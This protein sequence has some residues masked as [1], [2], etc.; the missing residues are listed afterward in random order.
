M[1]LTFEQA[2]GII[3]NR[4]GWR[5]PTGIRT[6][7]NNNPPP[8]VPT[9]QE[10]YAGDVA[11]GQPL[12]FGGSTAA[13]LEGFDEAQEFQSGVMDWIKN[14][15]SPFDR[16]EVQQTLSDLQIGSPYYNQQSQS[17]RND[18]AQNLRAQ[19]SAIGASLG[20][21]GI[22]GSPEASLNA[23]AIGGNLR[24]TSSALAELDR[25]I[26]GAR[27]NFLG[28]VTRTGGALGAA[29]IGGIAGQEPITFDYL[30][31]FMTQEG[32]AQ[33]EAAI[34]DYKS[35]QAAGQPFSPEW[36]KEQFAALLP[37]VALNPDLF[38]GG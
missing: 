35:S 3:R 37:I 21:R 18:S 34:N 32:L 2:Q 29:Q 5:G 1:P 13:N 17:I 8:R 26:L 30:E 28:D 36:I 11:L 10:A 23:Q 4:G 15:P 6:Y 38:F 16:P 12:T 7:G 20:A 25:N 22:G 27:T 19:Q 9:A 24:A 33:V 31:P 14:Y